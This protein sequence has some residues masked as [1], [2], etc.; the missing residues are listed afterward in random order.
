MPS[1]VSVAPTAGRNAS[2]NNHYAGLSTNS[3]RSGN[4]RKRER[5]LW[6]AFQYRVTLWIAKI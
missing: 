3:N 6:M 2:K 5:M 1:G 4:R